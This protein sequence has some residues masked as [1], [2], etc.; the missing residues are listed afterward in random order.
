MRSGKKEKGPSKDSFLPLTEA[1]GKLLLPL[2]HGVV[3]TDISPDD[4]V[5]A[6]C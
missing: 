3:G 6:C 5:G 4:N 2:S 1:L